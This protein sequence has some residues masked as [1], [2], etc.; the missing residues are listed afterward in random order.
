MTEGYDT[1]PTPVDARYVFEQIF[2]YLAIIL[3]SLQL[4][5]QAWLS[6]RTKSTE[7]VS[8]LC[9]LLWTW[10]APWLGVLTLYQM[11]SIPIV[12]QPHVFGA[13][14]LVCFLETLYYGKGIRGVRFGAHVAIQV[15]IYIAVE[16]GMYY[17]MEVGSKYT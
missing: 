11:V 2:G 6:F 10:S 15:I 3:W 12:I 4:A 5:P 7:G 9:M 1:V 14:A 17:A 8:S 16:V 13:L